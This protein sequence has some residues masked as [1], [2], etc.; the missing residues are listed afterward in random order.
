MSSPPDRVGGCDD[1]LWRVRCQRFKMSN[2]VVPSTTGAARFVSMMVSLSPYVSRSVPPTTPSHA[3][4]AGALGGGGL[5]RSV[6]I[7]YAVFFDHIHTPDLLPKHTLRLFDWVHEGKFVIASAAE[8]SLTD[9][10]NA[11]TA[12]ES[13]ATTGK[14]LLIP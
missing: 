9:A 14:L 3:T 13:R 10:A 12:M 8:Y 11:H 1:S 2:A 4:W 5:P 6:K 7:G